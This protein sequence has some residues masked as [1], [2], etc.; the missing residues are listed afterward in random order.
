MTNDDNNSDFHIKKGFTSYDYRSLPSLHSASA[1]AVASALTTEMSERHVGARWI[2]APLLYGA[3]TI[4]GLTR[5]YLDQH[6]A[7]DVVMGAFTGAFL[8]AKVVHH[9]HA[10]RR[11]RLDRFL[12]G[13]SV[14]PDTR[15]GAALA[16]NVPL[17]H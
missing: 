17:A 7:S 5:M 3:A 16:W 15:G 2:V 4:P 10:N 13:A 9:A 11:N 14:V 12:L 6:W 1:F 8:G